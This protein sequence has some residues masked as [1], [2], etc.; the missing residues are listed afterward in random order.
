M[1]EVKDKASKAKVLAPPAFPKEGRLPGTL[2]AVGKNYGQQTR[3]SDL[4]KQSRDE[5]GRL[6]HGNSCQEVHIGLFDGANS[7]N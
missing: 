7:N 5:N 1:Y 2:R 3:E 4:F 6:Q